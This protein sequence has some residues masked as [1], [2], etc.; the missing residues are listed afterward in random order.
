MFEKNR[1]VNK[2]IKQRHDIIRKLETAKEDIELNNELLK[3][4]QEITEETAKI[5][6]ELDTKV[7]KI[8]MDFEHELK[9]RI[10]YKRE[11][12]KEYRKLIDLYRYGMEIIEHIRAN[13]KELRGYLEN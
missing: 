3:I 9:G 5:L 4:T 13:K 7:H 6:N 8:N 12:R 1:S 2:L 10:N 11:M